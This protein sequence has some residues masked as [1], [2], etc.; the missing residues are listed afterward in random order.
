IGQ[1]ENKGIEISLNGVIVESNGWTWEAGINLYANRNKLVSLYSG[2][3]RNEANW[4]FVGHPID[5]I[6]DYKRIGLWQDEDPYRDILEPGRS[7]GMI[8]VQYTGSHNPDGT[9]TRAMGPDDRQIISL[10]PDFQGGFST[11]VTYKGFGLSA[12]G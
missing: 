7:V 1:T 9:P 10:E 2:A 5:V 6:F 12:V 4:W 8:K 11:R 3:D